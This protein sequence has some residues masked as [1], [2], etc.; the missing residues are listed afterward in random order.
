MESHLTKGEA[1][2]KRHSMDYIDPYTRKN[3]SEAMSWR[4]FLWY[5]SLIVM[6]FVA[7][8]LVHR[9]VE[10]TVPVAHADEKVAVLSDHQLEVQ[11]CLAYLTG[12][13]VVGGTDT[14]IRNHCKNYTK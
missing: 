2:L 7:T 4:T 1:F 11:Y 3:K 5:M 9:Y 6:V 13:P 8:Y 10:P 12:E 14:Q